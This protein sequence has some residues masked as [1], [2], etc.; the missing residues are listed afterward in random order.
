MLRQWYSRL[1]GL[2]AQD[3]LEIVTEMLEFWSP[4][5]RKQLEK[6]L[7][8]MN[9]VERQKLKETLAPLTFADSENVL[10]RVRM[11]LPF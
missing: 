1:S 9:S 3:N 4:L 6:R 10:V 5:E 8:D 2:V 11:R 7:L